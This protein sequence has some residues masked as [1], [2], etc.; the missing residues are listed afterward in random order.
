MHHPRS[1]RVPLGPT[2]WHA[3]RLPQRSFDHWKVGT[4]LY[5]DLRS[6]LLPSLSALLAT[7]YLI[8]LRLSL[9]LYFI[10]RSTTGCVSLYSTLYIS[11]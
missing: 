5:Y 8:L 10:S 2:V 1:R 9:C 3:G 4:A 6:P 11:Y 7:L